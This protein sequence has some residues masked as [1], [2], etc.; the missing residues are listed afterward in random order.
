M[1][2][3]DKLVLQMDPEDEDD[4]EDEEELI[5]DAKWLSAKKRRSGHSTST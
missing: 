4:D 5:L 3:F 1:S 2:L